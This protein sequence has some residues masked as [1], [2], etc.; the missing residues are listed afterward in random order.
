MLEPSLYEKLTIPN[1][2]KKEDIEKML[3][4]PVKEQDIS[5]VPKM[6]LA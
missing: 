1:V 5:D 2:A 4:P 6:Q 3:N